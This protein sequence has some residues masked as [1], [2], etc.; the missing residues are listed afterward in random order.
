[1]TEKERMQ[2]MA[3]GI[4]LA[5]SGFIS[6]MAVK[7]DQVQSVMLSAGITKE[8]WNACDDVISKDNIS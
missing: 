6:D 7:G 5:C 8:E 1:M 4:I 2:E 3:N